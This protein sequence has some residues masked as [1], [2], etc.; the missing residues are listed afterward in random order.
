MPVIKRTYR[1]EELKV[2][3]I[4]IPVLKLVSSE[5]ISKKRMNDEL[6]KIMEEMELSDYKKGEFIEYVISEGKT[7]YRKAIGKSTS[8][9]ELAKWPVRLKRVAVLDALPEKL[10][11]NEL[12]WYDVKGEY[13]VYEGKVRD[14]VLILDTEEGI[15]LAGEALESEVEEGKAQKSGA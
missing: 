11:L 6:E 13:Y 3:G 14:V 7:I 12:S 10:N 4:N 2:N 15:Y 5:S 9:G 8:R 1:V